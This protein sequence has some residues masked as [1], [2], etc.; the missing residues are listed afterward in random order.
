MMKYVL[1]LLALVCAVPALAEE[2]AKKSAYDRVMET[3][4]IRC[5]Y[6]SYKP[7]VYQDLET[8][9]MM[10]LNVEIMEEVARQLGM[11]LEWPEET[12][13]AN[14]PTA[15]NTGKVDAACSLLW[16]DPM[17]GKQVAY[18]RPAFY[19]A[20]HVYAKAGDARFTGKM[21]ELNNP[22]IKI[23]V[24]DGDITPELVKRYFPKAQIVALPQSASG[25]EIFLNVV[26]GKADVTFGDNIGVKN[27]NDANEVKLERI[28]LRRPVTVYANSIAVGIHETEL[29]E[30]LDATVAYLL[31]TGKIAEIVE[32]FSKEYP[33]AIV[34]SKRP[35]E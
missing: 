35:Y 4:T 17:R 33:D 6:G 5:G 20:L 31:D 26:T 28:P 10:G 29:K 27:F 34:L 13:W 16:I 25:S 24:Q 23:S 12:G 1:F 9:K 8:G 14:L 32:K 3:Q 19:N 22:D 30:M 18:T 2:G 15:L 11:K 21:E 7:W